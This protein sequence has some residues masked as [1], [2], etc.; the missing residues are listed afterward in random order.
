MKEYYPELVKNEDKIKEIIN[1]EEE[2]FAKT[3]LSGEKKLN[4]MLDHAVD[5]KLSGSDA[6]K[7]YD[8]YGFPFELT[9]EYLEEKGYTVD[10][11]EFDECMKVQKEMARTRKNK[12]R[13]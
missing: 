8:T 1:K 3:L 5:N 11:N 9:L 13:P 7:L 10:K 2:L 6:F 4:E 12:T